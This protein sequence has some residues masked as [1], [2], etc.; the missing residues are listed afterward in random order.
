MRRVKLFLKTPCRHRPSTF[1]LT[2]A[3]HG[4]LTWKGDYLKAGSKRV[5]KNYAKG[6]A[7]SIDASVSGKR[8][9]TGIQ[10]HAR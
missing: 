5:G 8:S 6:Y 2:E 7:T 10:L 4:P 9:H 1:L 3:A